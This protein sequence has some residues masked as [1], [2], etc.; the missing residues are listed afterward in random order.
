MCF[1]SYL[2]KKCKK[3]IGTCTYGIA[4]QRA[5]YVFP[6]SGDRRSASTTFVIACVADSCRGS[7]IDR[8]NDAVILQWNVAVKTAL[9]EGFLLRPVLQPLSCKGMLSEPQMQLCTWCTAATDTGAAYP[10]LIIS[11]TCM[12]IHLKNTN[13]AKLHS[14]EQIYPGFSNKKRRYS[15][16]QKRDAGKC[17]SNY[18]IEESTI[19]KI[20]SWNLWFSE[21]LANTRGFDIDPTTIVWFWWSRYIRSVNCG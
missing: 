16:A 8:L 4:L 10:V 17:I 21:C 9:S 5:T 6:S 2:L 20:Y 15:S 11:K 13:H 3:N 14:Y 19:P 12:Y 7:S 1:A 18:R